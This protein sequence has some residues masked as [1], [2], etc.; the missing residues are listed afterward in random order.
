MQLKRLSKKSKASLM[1]LVLLLMSASIVV[2]G[3][4]NAEEARTTGNEQIVVTVLSDHYDELSSIMV[5]AA[6]TGLNPGVDY[7]VSLTI[8]YDSSLL[9]SNGQNPAN[10]FSYDDYHCNDHMIDAYVYDAEN[11]EYVDYLWDDLVDV[12]TGVSTYAIAKAIEFQ[13]DSDIHPD[14]MGAFPCVDTSTIASWWLVNDGV[15]D[16]PDSSDEAFDYSTWP[17][18]ELDASYYYNCTDWETYGWDQPS[19]QWSWWSY[20][21]CGRGYYVIA[22]LLV[23]DY[24]LADAYSNSFAVGYKGHITFDSLRDETII[25]GQDYEFDFAACDLFEFITELVDYDLEYRVLNL[26]DMTVVSTG[27]HSQIDLRSTTSDCSNAQSESI[28][29]LSAG[30]YRL[31]ITLEQ[32]GVLLETSTRVIGVSTT[33]ISGAEDIQITTNTHYYDETADLVVQIDLSD[34]HASTSYTVDLTFCKVRWYFG[35]PQT[36]DGTLYN[37]WE[38]VCMEV[39]RPMI[40]D[41]ETDQYEEETALQ[42]IEV[43]NGG[44]VQQLQVTLHQQYDSDQHPDG[45]GAFTCDDGSTIAS[46]WLVND[47]N[48]DCADG[49]DEGYDY[50]DWPTEPISATFWTSEIGYWFEAKLQASS[51]VVSDAFSNSFAAGTKGTIQ[52]KALHP[53]GV[54]NGMDYEFDMRVKH[55]FRYIDTLVEYDLNYEVYDSSSSLVDSGTHSQIDSRSLTAWAVSW[56]TIAISGLVPGSYTLEIT[57]VQEGVEIRHYNKDFDIIDE[58]L[59]NLES[60]EVSVDSNH[61]EATEDIELTISLDNLYAGTNYEVNWRICRD[62]F[63]LDQFPNPADGE[64]FDKYDCPGTVGT[65]P[66]VYDASTDSYTDA[67]DILSPIPAGSTSFTETVTIHSEYS[68]DIDPWNLGDYTCD[69]GSILGM[70]WTLIN[71]GNVDCTDGSDEGFDYANWPTEVVTNPLINYMEQEGYY[72]TAEIQVAGFEVVDAYTDSFAVGEI[73]HIDFSAPHES[74]VLT[75]MDYKFQYSACELFRYINSPIDYNLDYWVFDDNNGLVSSGTNQ[76]ID[77][78]GMGDYC[79]SPELIFVS[80]LSVDQGK[81]NKHYNL[82]I[83]LTMEGDIIDELDLDFTVTDPLAPNDDATLSVSSSTDANGVGSV[84][85]T[86]DEMSEGQYYEVVYTIGV[87]GGQPEVGNYVMIA[88]PLTDVRIISFPHLQ[89]GMYCLNAELKIDT[90]QLR[91]TAACFNQASTIDTDGDGIR[92]IED[93]CPNEDATPG[94]DANGDG[95]IEHPDTDGD[96]WDDVDEV[97]CMTD[98][99][100]ILIY[101]TDTDGD[102]DCDLIDDDDDNDGV[103]DLIEIAAGSDPLNDQ[104]KPNSPPTCAI[105][106]ALETAGIV[107]V[108]DNVVIAAVTAG[109]PTVPTSITV[110][111]PEGNYYLI[112]KC[113]DPE[114]DMVTANINGE[115]IGPTSEATVGALVIMAPDTSETIDLM[116]AYDDGVHFLAAQITVNLDA[117]AGMPSV[118]DDSTGQGVPGF[119][120]IIGMVALLGAA[121]A[122]SRKNRI[123]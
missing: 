33:S 96:G 17:T 7:D 36:S 24:E 6:L 3:Q 111:L 73:G 58:T 71:D 116:L 54:L 87:A 51:Y 115:L 55:I 83:M 114:G 5:G 52:Y 95:C 38:N 21:G 97:A 120:G 103:K 18:E 66:Q 122:S 119:T 35:F 105:Y 85:F 45:M 92:D 4:A 59:S 31:D 67:W 48:A 108:N 79:S 37:D 11:D 82:K 101:P 121:L 1:I 57:L 106:Y 90:W 72:I 91:S 23:G 68:S 80:G 65:G 62:T 98:P 53:N 102:G 99:N 110:T 26:A 41:A 49:T 123:A 61:Y 86:V 56:E 117:G 77:S 2:G 10:G 112:A 89:D 20:D 107:V 50:A 64:M 118:V 40:Y 75:G 94:P 81:R 43:P 60:M 12:P 47:G 28:P 8:C 88:P 34:L 46:W 44:G 42:S 100:E 14:D 104:S 69:D 27:S 29:G 74:G 84:E 9:P 113:S 32:E 70:G 13:R 63:E 39:N 30:N 93:V 22:E 19:L 78:R 109:T 16:C 15:A 76:L 25:V